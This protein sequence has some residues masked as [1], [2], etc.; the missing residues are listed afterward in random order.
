VAL[1]LIPT[2]RKGREGGRE[3][4]RKEEL[5]KLNDLVDC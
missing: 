3:E 5:N 1:G 2:E 4:G